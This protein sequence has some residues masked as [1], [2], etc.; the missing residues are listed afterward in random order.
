MNCEQ[1][2]L[3]TGRQEDGKQLSEREEQLLQDHFKGCYECQKLEI[4]DDLLRGWS[5]E[6]GLS[7]QIGEAK[8]ENIKFL[9]TPSDFFTAPSDY[10]SK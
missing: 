1:A 5:K 7:K 10:I 2:F 4:V 9:K 8:V 6:K 3:L